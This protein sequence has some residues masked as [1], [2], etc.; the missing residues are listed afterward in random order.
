[1]SENTFNIEAEVANIKKNRS[2][3]ILRIALATVGDGKLLDARQ[4]FVPEG[5][6]TYTTTRKG[7]SISVRKLDELISALVAA[8]RKAEELGWIEPEAPQQR[9]AA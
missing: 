6:S 7:F 4:M 5:S 3:D 2:G 1:V 9:K 8:K